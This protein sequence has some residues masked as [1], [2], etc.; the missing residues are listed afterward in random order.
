[1]ARTI[2]CSIL[3]TDMETP[4]N[5]AVLT[6]L[7]NIFS[8][9]RIKH[10]CVYTVSRIVRNYVELITSNSYCAIS[11]VIIAPM[12]KAY[13]IY[14]LANHDQYHFSLQ[15]SRPYYFC[16]SIRNKQYVEEHHAFEYYQ[17]RTTDWKEKCCNCILPQGKF[18]VKRPK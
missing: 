16:N 11:C 15:F 7:S 18:H 2:D 10:V 6:I 17:L 1:M 12:P 3:A 5:Y 9:D 14:F 4:M 8:G 13:M